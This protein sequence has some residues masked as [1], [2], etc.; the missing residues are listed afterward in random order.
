MTGESLGVAVAFSAGLKANPRQ[1]SGVVGEGT[2]RKPRAS[3]PSTFWESSAMA[4]SNA[5][6]TPSYVRGYRKLSR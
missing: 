3:H 4:R 6:F 1:P 5:A 2:M